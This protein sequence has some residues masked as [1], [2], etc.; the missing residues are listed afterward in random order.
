MGFTGDLFDTR[1]CSRFLFRRS[2]TRIARHSFP[3]V[4][5][6]LAGHQPGCY[7]FLY[8]ALAFVYARF[9]PSFLF[10][11]L[12]TPAPTQHHH[13][14]LSSS[15][16]RHVIVDRVLAS[17]LHCR[18]Y[19]ISGLLPPESKADGEEGFLSILSINRDDERA[20]SS[21]IYPSPLFTLHRHPSVTIARRA[22]INTSPLACTTRNRDTRHN[23][24]NQ[25]D[26]EDK[27]HRRAHT[28][29]SSRA[30]S[31]HASSSFSH[32]PGSPM[33]FL[34]VYLVYP[35]NSYFEGKRSHQRETPG[36]SSYPGPCT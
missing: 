32:F 22:Y 27:S 30:L 2:R 20:S 10:L 6:G 11:F 17:R 13:P 23:T 1:S 31:P 7:T 4:Y 33:R 34:L 15:C 24:E 35:L 25:I 16:T 28:H 29:L 26:T 5:L 8:S 3:F 21:L 12:A 9:L 18:R 14:S 19:C 36:R